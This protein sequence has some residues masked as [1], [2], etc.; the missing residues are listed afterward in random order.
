MSAEVTMEEYLAAKET[1]K[2][3]EICSGCKKLFSKA[4]TEKTIQ[5]AQV[6]H[7]CKVCY[8]AVKNEW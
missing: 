8:E 4:E 1:V 5:Y 7:W 3:H 2:N 6:H